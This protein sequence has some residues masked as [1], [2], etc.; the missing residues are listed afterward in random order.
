M[1]SSKSRE[2]RFKFSSVRIFIDLPGRF[3][4]GGERRPGVGSAAG[5]AGTP[6]A[7][8]G[9]SS[10]QASAS[11]TASAPA[12]ARSGTSA[13][14]PARP[15]EIIVKNILK[16]EIRPNIRKRSTKSVENTFAFLE[17]H[18]FEIHFSL[19]LFY[20][21]GLGIVVL[22]VLVPQPYMFPFAF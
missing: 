22:H 1:Y 5:P 8:P 3:S 20:T 12:V 21:C 2:V 10:A 6:H 9:C 14:A 16:Y 18:I 4:A 11:R 13:S 7:G 17:N 19:T 15:H